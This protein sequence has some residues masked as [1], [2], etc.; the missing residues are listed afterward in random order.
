MNNSNL[1]I[2]VQKLISDY[3]LNIKSKIKYSIN[4]EAFYTLRG[5]KYNGS[6]ISRENAFIFGKLKS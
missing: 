4:K 2:Y 6:Q 5:I 1:T 3:G